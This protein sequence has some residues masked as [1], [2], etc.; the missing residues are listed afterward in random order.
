MLMSDRTRNELKQRAAAY[1]AAGIQ[2]TAWQIIKDII[3]VDTVN[4][5]ACRRCSRFGNCRHYGRDFNSSL[6]EVL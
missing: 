6:K 2:L 3:E 4:A 5:L 1:K